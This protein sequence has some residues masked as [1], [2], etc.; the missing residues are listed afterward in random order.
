M[1]VDILSKGVE[2]AW[3]LFAG[4]QP[5]ETNYPL[6]HFIIEQC[7]QEIR[8]PILQNAAMNNCYEQGH[9][10]NLALVCTDWYECIKKKLLPK[11]SLNSKLIYTP[12]TINDHYIYEIFLRGG[13]NLQ[14]Q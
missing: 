8:T 4:S 10:G 14:A 7:P 2:I 11:M 13:I 9:V 5:I 6:G 1:T 12:Q 3:S